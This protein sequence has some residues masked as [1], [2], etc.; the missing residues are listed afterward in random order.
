[1][2]NLIAPAAIALCGL[3]LFGGCVASVGGGPK[4]TINKATTGQQLIDLQNAKNAGA[5]TDAE[6]QQQ[7]TKLLETK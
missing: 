1:M 2:K 7:K 6:Y 3:L 4:T 5:I